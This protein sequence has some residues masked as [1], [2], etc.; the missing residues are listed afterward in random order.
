MAFMRDPSKSQTLPD[1][2]LVNE[3]IAYIKETF[4]SITDKWKYTL[5]FRNS[6][7][8]TQPLKPE[9]VENLRETIKKLDNQTA[10]DFIACKD[11]INDLTGEFILQVKLDK[12]NMPNQNIPDQG[13]GQQSGYR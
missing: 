10:Y 9:I 5:V 8:F 11:D 1:N 3:K 12:I 2:D 7:L 4:S 6:I 13:Y